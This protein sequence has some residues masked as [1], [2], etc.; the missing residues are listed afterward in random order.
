VGAAA[1]MR[2]FTSGHWIKNGCLLT[3]ENGRPANKEL[4][5]TKRRDLITLS[6]INSSAEPRH[7]LADT[8]PALRFVRFSV[9]TGRPS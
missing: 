6:A 8:K 7:R 1:K 4:R 9:D 2:G 5:L 3:N